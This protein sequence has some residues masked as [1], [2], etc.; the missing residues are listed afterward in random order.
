MIRTRR[1]RKFARDWK[2]VP[3]RDVP[4]YSVTERVVNEEI[5]NEFL[6][7]CVAWCYKKFGEKP[8]VDLPF[9]EWDFNN[10]SY[11][12]DGTLGEYDTI[13]NTIY[14][15]ITGHRNFYNLARTLIHEYV[16]YL[17][18][19]YSDQLYTEYM[20]IYG[21]EDNPYEVEAVY[22]SELY[23]VECTK[24]VLTQM[25]DSIKKQQR[26]LRSYDKHK[27]KTSSRI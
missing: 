26:K 19:E 21:Y 16:H 18:T 15:R 23:M 14:L 27:R 17:Q 12:R 4:I 1:L 6:D 11:Q 20:K 24:W 8:K 7:Y 25:M 5:I 22:I 3:N 9:I 2:Y 13:Q 10:R